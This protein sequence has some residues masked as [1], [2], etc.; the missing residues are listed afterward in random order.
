[1][2]IEV[3]QITIIIDTNRPNKSKNDLLTK[4]I[5]YGYNSSYK[6]KFYEEFPF[7][8]KSV[9][10]PKDYLRRKTF[11]EK[12]MFFFNRKTF[13]DT[14]SNKNVMNQY[15]F[16]EGEMAGGDGKYKKNG[17]DS[18][19][20]VVHDSGIDTSICNIKP[21]KNEEDDNKVIEYNLATM[22][23]LLF[24]TVYPSV[25]DNSDSFNK[26][27]MKSGQYTLS[28]DGT[29]P[30]L[31]K[32]IIP[33]LNVEFSYI[34][35]D[36][37]EYTVTSTCIL[38][39]I[40]NHPEYNKLIHK[41]VEFKKWKIQ[42]M[43]EVE[44]KITRIIKK[45]RFNI[46]NNFDDNDKVLYEVTKNIREYNHYEPNP[47]IRDKVNGINKL[48]DKFVDIT[49]VIDYDD[50]NI[51]DKI[52]NNLNKNRPYPLDICGNIVVGSDN[53]IYNTEIL[54]EINGKKNN[55]NY[56]FKT[57][58]KLINDY[59][60]DIIKNIRRILDHKYSFQVIRSL[61]D[62]YLMM[63]VIK[64]KYFDK[65]DTKNP[66][67]DYDVISS[68][69]E[70]YFKNNYTKYAELITYISKFVSPNCVSS[71]R[72]L[73]CMINTF[74]ENKNDVLENS[75][76]QVFEK[77]IDD[78]NNT[79]R[80]SE[81]A[82]SSLFTGVNSYN[83]E[84]N[85][86]KLKY[87]AYVSFN[88]ISGKLTHDDLSN[89]SCEYKDEELG[90]NFV[91]GRSDKLIKSSIHVSTLIDRE[92]MIKNSG[93]DAKVIGGKRKRRNTIRKKTT[94]YKRYS[95]KKKTMKCRSK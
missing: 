45:I 86:G 88:L 2:D 50:I 41:L 29:I 28:L 21:S 69:I 6:D 34:I 95:N 72:N 33:S 76:K 8:T 52:E 58:K 79:Q 22:I 74:F 90:N 14:L 16:N 78:A 11:D 17:G 44:M 87:E 20:K 10:I 82:S 71:N 91:R 56:L 73:Q 81:I 37:K 15:E 62:E 48:F 92:K 42:T 53:E 83:T 1:M 85:F 9:R 24:T 84:N 89:I 23:E 18:S 3:E 60:D 32:S 65:K 66:N 68:E 26:L 36:G 61:I 4:H 5:F 19:E 54:R 31:F 49:D 43:N 59:T 12:I 25:N 30:K 39:D 55:K 13:I 80:I 63:M 75:M 77:Y 70:K 94:R 64:R 57:D 93:E 40:I 35:L 46:T 27:I 51:I 38:N 7:F 47:G 67:V